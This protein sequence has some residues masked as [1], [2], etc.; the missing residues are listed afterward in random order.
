VVD[1]AQREGLPS[2]ITRGYLQLARAQRATGRDGES[3][4]RYLGRCLESA[5][6]IGAL[7]EQIRSRIMLAEADIQEGRLE[8]AAEH[9]SASK[10]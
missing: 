8:S 10:S 4:R 3:T 1:L 7:P 5:E 9:L 6:K 2:W